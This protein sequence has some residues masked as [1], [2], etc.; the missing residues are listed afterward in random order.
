MKSD[1]TFWN[2]DKLS[3][4]EK[5]KLSDYHILA[6]DLPVLLCRFKKDGTIFF[7]NKSYAKF[8]NTSKDSLI[9]SKFFISPSEFEKTDSSKPFL[10]QYKKQ[11][12]L[13]LNNGSIHWIE[14]TVNRISD[15]N[16]D[17]F[18]YQAVGQDISEHKLLEEHLSK[19]S[20]AVE[21]SNSTVLIT[22]TEGNI[23]YVNPRFSE[24]TGYTAEEAKGKNTR[25]LKSNRNDAN[26]YTEL[27]ST[28]SNG[29]E[30][31]GELL[32][33]KKNGELF[34]ELVSISP[35]KNDKGKIT[36]Y[37]AVKEDISEHKKSEK[38]EK[39]LYQISRAVIDNEELGSLYSSIHKS[40]SDILPVENLFIA[41][42][43]Q[44]KNLLSFPYFVDEFDEA[45]ETGPPGRG[46]TEYVLRSGKP[47]HVDQE[48]FKSLVE[49]GEVDLYGTD[50]L[51]WIG[52]PLKIGDNTIGVLVVQSYNE[53]IRLDERD[54]NVLIY[55]SDQIALAIERTRTHNLLK[56]SE[57][58]FRLLFD[59]AADLIIIINP[60]GKVLDINN[61]FE[62]ETGYRRKDIIGE[63]L[64][65]SGL[66]PSRS[67]VSTAFYF[68][69]LVIGKDIPIFEID[70]IKK[71][72][73]LITYELRAVPIQEKDEPIGIQAILRNITDRKRTE[74]KLY[75]SEKHL[76]NLMSNL[77]GMAYRCRYDHDWTMEF[78]SQGCLAL[79][80]YLPEELVLNSKASYTELIHPEDKKN[81]F[82]TIRESIN[83]RTPFQ[84]IYRIR[85]KDGGEKWVWEKGDAQ[86]SRKGKVETLEG[87]ITD[88][89]S[90][91]NA[92][93]ALKESE[94]LYRKL[95]ATLPD[96]IAIT[97]VKG[98]I[99]FLNEIG[100]RFTGYSSFE[101]VKHQNFIN[102][103]AEEDKELVINNFKK[104]FSKNIGTQEYHFNNKNGERFLFEIHREVLR[105]F[106]GSPYGL[107]FSCRDITS[108]KKAETELAQSEEKYRTLIDS[109]QD[110]VFLIV[111]GIIL[112]VNRAFC[113]M[114]GYE[115]SEIEGVSFLKFVTPEDVELV[116]GNYKL[117]Q[118]GKSAPSSYE[119]RML[120]K[121]GGKVF[122]NMSARVINYQGKRATIGTLKDI[123]HQ[124]KLEQI[125]HNQKNLFKGVADAANILLT[126]KDF[127]LAITNTLKS[128]GQS[129]DIDRVYIFEN[130]VDSITEEP[131]MNQKFEWT[132][133]TVSSEINNTDLQNLHYYPMFESWY[134]IL[135]SGNIINSLVR[136][137]N[138]ALRELLNNQNIKSILLVPIMVKNDFWGFIGFDYCKSDRIWSEIE[139]SI[140]QTTAA[141]LGGVIERELAK[142]ELIEAKETAEEMSKLKSN[143]LANMSHELRTPLIAILGYTEILKSE[144]EHHEW[145]DMISTIMQSGKRLLETLNL[146]LDLSKVEADKVQI[147][148]SEINIAEEVFDIVNMFNPVAQKKNLYLKSA[149][150]KEVVLSKLDKRLLHS[151]IT[152]LVNNAIKYT[153]NGGIIVELSVI[154]SNKKEYAMIRVVDTGIGIAKEDQE[155]IFDEFR[156]VSEGYNRHFEGAGLGLTIAK[157]F[158]EKMGGSISL[159][160]KVG[161]GS[162]FTVVFSCADE[163]V[164]SEPSKLIA[165]EDILP[166]SVGKNKRVLVVDDD[167]ATRKIVE[168]FLRGEIEI[169][170]ASN[171]EDATDMINNYVYSL[172]LMDISLGKGISGVDLLNN[173]RQLPSYKNVP[174]LAVTAHAMVGDK[175]KFLSMGFDDYLSKPF[176][177]KDLVNKVR[178]WVSNGNSNS[179]NY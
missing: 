156:Q 124:K 11:F 125:L 76:S 155:N 160:S 69:K 37:V 89:S 9:G 162:T 77:P 149:V 117:R 144:I 60:Q 79:T 96:I 5:R 95:I 131:V 116:A 98:D 55:V 54:L 119:W 6:D 104:N 80:G 34:W 85:T 83:K 90:R 159:E 26:I 92:E 47:L 39:A 93:A 15:K 109:I 108:R 174:V 152:N 153:Q 1:K 3:E 113:K 102:F 120:H 53:N 33:K 13:K 126:E 97:D 146:V 70:V 17:G 42:F 38:L 62:E 73:A 147:N 25:I 133:G 84:I 2:D 82:I 64:F 148:Y 23:E 14:W 132:N 172:V 12:S 7:T 86:T 56:S 88:I 100:V 27:W 28:I 110:G 49:A 107:I 137:L 35:V 170:S 105:T 157:K 63:N 59:K 94:E 22:D 122:V 112:F 111:D 145:N 129:S 128:L 150:E 58:R 178:N 18:D 101:E 106:D 48:I 68:S 123:T 143:F 169:E 158:V 21:Q 141:N 72:A 166:Y 139:I 115:N 41:L 168:L 52:V 173:L 134:P 67:A 36:N 75:Q 142:V 175:E 127:S 87:F 40:L 140:L 99:I 8:F 10:N 24:I 121:N 81:V 130:S 16:S 176:G 177:K 171:S 91:I 29:I 65:T 179:K 44:Q 151:V 61:I 154:N 43:D 163:L 32:N 19:I 46:L 138:P 165:R 74:A 50:S 161:K 136:D 114:I 164:K 20:V 4:G 30:W 31:Q 78:V 71:D 66:L 135:K 51:D 118:E 45:Y 103:I 57:E 167:L